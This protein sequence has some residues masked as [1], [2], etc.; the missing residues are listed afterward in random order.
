MWRQ[1]IARRSTPVWLH[2]A[3]PPWNEGMGLANT[4]YDETMLAKRE[5]QADDL[6]ERYIKMCVLEHAANSKSEHG[7]GQDFR[8]LQLRNINGSNGNSLFQTYTYPN[9]F[10]K[11][12]KTSPAIF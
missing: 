6:R 5:R 2:D 7:G 10:Y 9:R 1:R 3:N 8:Q 12:N 11:I 4:R